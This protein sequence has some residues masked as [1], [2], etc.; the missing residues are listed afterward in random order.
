MPFYDVYFPYASFL[1]INGEP[2][3]NGYVY[4]GEPSLNPV[5][6][7]ITIYWDKSTNYPISQPIRTINGYP[8][9]NGTPHN[10]F[11]DLDSNDGYSMSVYSKE[12]ALLFT[13]EFQ[14]S[15]PG[16]GN[17]ALKDEDETITGAWTF[18][19]EVVINGFSSATYAQLFANE[20]VTGTW[21]FNNPITV[22]GV[23]SSQYAVVSD[24]ETVTGTWTF[25]NELSINGV[26]SADY[27]VVSANET[28][29]GTWTFDNELS[30]NG[31]SSADY[32]VVS[33]N[34]TISGDYDFTGALTK[35]SK[36]IYSAENGPL[37]GFRNKIINGNFDLWQRGTNQSAADNGY[38]CIDRWYNFYSGATRTVSQSAFTV[39]QTDIPG[40]P[41]F[42]LSTDIT[43][44]GA[45]SSD[46]V[47]LQ[48]RIFDVRTL[49][50]Q[51]VALSFY[52]KANTAIN[53]ATEFLQTFGSGSSTSAVAGIGVTTHA[54]TTS[55]QKFTLTASIPS[56]SGADIQSDNHSLRLYFIFSAGSDYDS[57]SN[58][59]GLQIGTFDIAQVQ[60]EPGIYV[61]PFEQRPESIEKILCK[62][63]FNRLI[64]DTDRLPFAAGRITG[65]A[66]A[67]V[68][69]LFQNEMRDR[70]AITFSS[71]TGFDIGDGG[72]ST[73]SVTATVL[74]WTKQGVDIELG[75]TLTNVTGGTNARLR[76][77]EYI[78]FNSEL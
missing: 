44:S 75:A 67:V 19:Q 57:Q 25:D 64:A 53:I 48:Q 30:I 70:P 46:A 9:R 38:G 34:E 51:A 72:G 14:Y 33:A 71:A 36:I 2:L 27:A 18:T 16:A 49:A 8:S 77:G 22:N 54:L 23:N 12:H 31:V 43:A 11:V 56:I 10:M 24:N 5:T 6:S 74:D 17:V 21:Q 68:N 66:T 63:F 52:A 50:G 47:I 29:T 39:G 41:K 59:L 42:Y 1:D 65:V 7:P 13:S 61:T 62:Y 69:F 4:I 55:W 40:E 45:A 73:Q 37:A 26:S 20:T 15:D 60:L 76:T 35:N 32:A 78:D 28:V 3:Q 58:S